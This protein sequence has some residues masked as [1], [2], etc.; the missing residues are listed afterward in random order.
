MRVEDRN[1]MLKPLDYQSVPEDRPHLAFFA[2]E[3]WGVILPLVRRLAFAAG[4]GFLAFGAGHLFCEH[5]YY[6]DAGARQWGWSDNTGPQAMG[7]GGALIGL[8]IP[9]FGRK[10]ARG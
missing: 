10:Q 3:A 1:E 9:I 5:Y 7:F 4:M 6:A 2:G 8:T